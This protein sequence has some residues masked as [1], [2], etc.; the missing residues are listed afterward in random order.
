MVLLQQGVVVG[1]TFVDLGRQMGGPPL[2][3]EFV[4]AEAKLLGYAIPKSSRNLCIM[5]RTFS[6]RYDWP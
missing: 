6:T 1:D 3:L 4:E 2:F 5:W